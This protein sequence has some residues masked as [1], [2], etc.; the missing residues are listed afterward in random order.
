ML[1][2]SA[3]KHSPLVDEPAHLAAGLSHWKRFAF[4][5]YRVN[6]PLVRSVAAIPLLFLHHEED[7]NHYSENQYKRAE[8]QVGSDFIK[9]NA[10]KYHNLLFIARLFCI[11]FS[12]LGAY[13]CYRWGRDLFGDISGITAL[14]LWCFSP[15]IL[16][17]GYTIMPDVACASVGLTACYFYW[18]WIKHPGWNK[19][20]LLG[21]LLGIAELTKF[22]LIVFYPVWLLVWGIVIVL[23]RKICSQ[24]LIF[25]QSK[26]LVSVFAISLFVINMGYGFEGSFIQLK[27]YEFVSRSLCGKTKWNIETGF[28][29]TG[30][31]FRDS[32]VGVIPIPL[33]ANY[34]MGI[35]VQKKDFE[36]GQP[37]YLQGEWRNDGWYHYYIL[38]LLIKEPLGFWFL[39]MIVPF[40]MMFSK[41]FRSDSTSEMILIFPVIIIFILVSSQ[42]KLNHHLRYVI[43][44]LPF[45]FLE[46]SRLAIAFRKNKRVLSGVIMCLLVWSIFSSLYFYPHSQGHFNGLIGSPRNAPK[47][48]LGSNIDW[49]QNELY[50]VDWYKNHPEARPFTNYYDSRYSKENVNINDDDFIDNNQPLANEPEAGWFAVG[51]NEL[52]GSTKQY[53]YFKLFEPVDYVGHSIYIYHI[54]I[55]DINRVRQKLE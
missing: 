37:S 46:I 32:M 22:T 12:L 8:F 14:V 20:L 10:K 21:I 15:M 6:P 53:E 26:Q 36:L 5:L 45:L 18:K 42:T 27:D 25:I 33:P 51:V 2:W 41:V 17:F 34:V 13:I 7:W 28:T 24:S 44:I 19:V 23:N 54:T 52:Y 47:Y 38:G 3:Y 50:L 31:R 1:V 55:D 35:D 11:P 4:D 9:C 40:V 39:L 16:A 48:L 30:N 29:V 43:P 49:G